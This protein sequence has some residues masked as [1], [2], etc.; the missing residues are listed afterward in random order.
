MTNLGAGELLLIVFV[1]LLVFTAGRLPAIGDA[2][3]R[4]LRGRSKPP[5]GQ[6]P[7]PKDG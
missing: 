2:I 5:A 1:L 4:T 7:A 6:P 3:G